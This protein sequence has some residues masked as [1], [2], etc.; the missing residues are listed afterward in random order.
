MCIISSWL[1]YCCINII[2]NLLS[3]SVDKPFPSFLC[4]P[5]FPF[6]PS[7]VVLIIFH[8]RIYCWKFLDYQLQLNYLMYSNLKIFI[9][10]CD[11]ISISTK[12]VKVSLL[13]LNSPPS[14]VICNLS[15][16][17][18]WFMYSCICY[19]WCVLARY[20]WC[21]Q[22]PQCCGLLARHHWCVL[23]RYRC[24]FVNTIGISGGNFTYKL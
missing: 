10:W 5:H 12:K 16:V 14:S 6:V 2:I 1:K 17:V 20:H 18:G 15:S 22:A 13:L 7:L 19:H 8:P 9:S 11:F 23:A 4:D 3:I 24:V 21:V